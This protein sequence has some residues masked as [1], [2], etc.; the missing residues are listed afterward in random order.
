[1]YGG[2]PIPFEDEKYDNGG[3]GLKFIGFTDI[4]KI[5][6]SYFTGG[7][8][9]V[10]V[11]QDGMVSSAKRFAAML[12][13]MHNKQ[14]A[15]I[16]RYTYSN[17]SGPKVMALFPDENCMLMYELFYK[18]S[19]VDL[20]F[21][22]LISKTT[23]PSAE[24]L[25]AMSRF[26]DSMDLSSGDNDKKNVNDGEPEPFKKLLDP[27]LQHMYRCIANRAINP[28]EPVLKVDDEIMSLV[29]PPKRDT[30]IDEL[31][32]LFPLEPAKLTAKEAFLQNI[33]KV[34]K[35]EDDS[36]NPAKRPKYQ[37][38]HEIGTVKPA[39]DFV[40]LLEFGEAFS[41]L[42][43]Q[44]QTVINNLVLKSIVAMDEKVLQ[45]LLAYRE[46][47]KQKAPFR[48]NEW[49]AQFKEVLKER[50]KIQ[51][52]QSII[53]ENLGLI[54]ANESEMSTVSDEEAQRFFKS[55][56]FNTQHNQSNNNEIENSDM[57]MFDDM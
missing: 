24:Q 17:N 13:A 27:G 28:S 54:T 47:A 20:R 14:Y 55:D 38:V 39:E 9:W 34:E 29:R 5:R 33:L 15:I 22:K 36:D 32:T 35:Q 12:Q 7:T 57:D 50:E 37:D 23:T 46:T 1:M 40:K 4:A 41:L 3:R 31:K 48:Y 51:L 44:I 25:E 21:P 42:A 18:D 2:E 49:I 43:E 53:N 6:D 10:V 56:D 26:V 30:N 11:P 16:A 19:Y 45:A 8:I 52:W